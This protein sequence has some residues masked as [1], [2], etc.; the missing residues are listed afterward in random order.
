MN[1]SIRMG[2]IEMYESPIS[3]EHVPPKIAWDDFTDAMAK[4]GAKKLDE[5]ILKAVGEVKVNVNQDELEKAL[6]Y[7]R[8]QFKKG[9]AAGV[10]WAGLAKECNKDENA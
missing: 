6:Q 5:M 3:I 2:A 8:D 1:D 10:E 4:A 7:D 9:F